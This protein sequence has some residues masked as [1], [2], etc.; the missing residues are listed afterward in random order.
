MSPVRLP[1]FARSA[2]SGLQRFDS[3]VVQAFRPA[4]KQE[5]IA[6]TVEDE[7]IRG[8]PDYADSG[9]AR[10]PQIMPIHAD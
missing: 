7:I 5:H 9:T 4:K 10:V 3:G 1:E 2:D 8:L 6:E